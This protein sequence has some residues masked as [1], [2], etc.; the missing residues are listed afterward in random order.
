MRIHLQTD[1]PQFFA[2]I[3]DVLRIFWGEAQVIPGG[4]ADAV[5]IHHHNKHGGEW[6]DTYIWETNGQ[7]ASFTDRKPVVSGPLVG[8]RMQKRAVKTCCY[9]LMKG[10]TG[11]QP[12]W[13]SLTGIRPTR[14]YYER[15][16]GDDTPEQ[17]EAALVS[18]FDLAPPKAALL[19]EIV[20]SQRGLL[21]IEDDALDVYCGIPF[22]P[23]RCDYCSFP[24]AAIG[25]NKLVSSYLD[26]LRLEIE[27]MGALVQARGQRVRA[28]Y[29]GG[30]TPTALT[31]LQLNDVLRA[32]G[33]AFPGSVEWTVEAGRPDSL[34]GEKLTMLRDFPITRIS[35]NPQSMRNATLE[36]IGRAH[37]AEQI[38]L[39]YEQA[40]T[41]GFRNINMDLICALPGENEQDFADTLER[42]ANLGPESLT[43]HTLAIKRASKLRDMAHQ[44]CDPE[45]AAR[46][47]EMGRQAARAMGMRAYYL[48]RQKYMAGNLENVGY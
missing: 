20:E 25:K 5:L 47:V 22:C 45:V 6:V 9:A 19:G 32:L 24:A 15:L 43:V 33:R 27:A 10:I 30:G 35:I 44:L 17:A 46:M 38:E 37:T 26:A 1:T 29:V 2:D 18:L 40:R 36:R 8:K 11:L 41:A 21:T 28:I 3:A 39:A 48:Y 34:D 13:G 16:A 7:S 23:T 42:V 14:L 12:P 31:V 4:E